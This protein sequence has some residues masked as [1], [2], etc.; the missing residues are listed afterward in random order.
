[1]TDNRIYTSRRIAIVEALVEQL[2]GINGNYPFRSNVYNNVLPRLKFW[3][4]VR[5]FPAIHVN[6]GS[7]VRQ[8]QGGGYKDRFMSATIRIYVNSE[9]P[10]GDL[11]ILFEDVE[12]VLED[13]SRLAYEDQDGNTQY[14][15]QI[16]ILSLDSDEGA[17][18]PMGVGEIV[19][20]V[21]Y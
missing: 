7:E 14:V 13:N 10:Q 19:C 15:Q 21:R 12:T 9:D 2:K 5:D 20:E 16:T 4:E 17:L 6:A 18:T 1:M 11:E 3:D 8:Y